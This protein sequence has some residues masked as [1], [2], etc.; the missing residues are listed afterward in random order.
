MFSPLHAFGIDDIEIDEPLP[1]ASTSSDD[2]KNI[3]RGKS[4][5][6][7]LISCMF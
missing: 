7:I 2:S 1:M 4:G 3:K 6:L 5:L